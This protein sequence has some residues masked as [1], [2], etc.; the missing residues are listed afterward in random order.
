MTAELDKTGEVT[1]RPDA[2]G[3]DARPHTHTLE[4]PWQADTAVT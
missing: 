1:E 3:G 2:R 4:S